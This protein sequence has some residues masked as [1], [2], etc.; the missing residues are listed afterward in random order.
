MT[1]SSLKRAPRSQPTDLNETTYLEFIIGDDDVI[2]AREVQ[3]ECQWHPLTS[4]TPNREWYG[5]IKNNK[6][7]R[8]KRASTDTRMKECTKAGS[9]A[10]KSQSSSQSWSTEVNKA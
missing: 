5:Y 6:K 9:K 7:N 2:P 10:R 4:S 1:T 3:D 8:E